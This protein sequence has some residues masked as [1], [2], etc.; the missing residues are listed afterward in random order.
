ML[1]WYIQQG[2]ERPIYM[3]QREPLVRASTAYP[4]AAM[5]A[6]FGPGRFGCQ[7]DYMAA[8][9]LAEEFDH[10]ILY[11]IGQ[12]YVADPYGAAA[13][14]WVRLHRTFLW[15][16]RLARARDVQLTWAGPNM[17]RPDI[18]GGDAPPETP[19]I[20]AYGYDMGSDLDAAMAEQRGGFAW[21]DVTPA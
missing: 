20:A 4:R 19:L 15:W 18:R 6:A 2:P 3:V 8:L 13:E 12:P 7:L 11:G 17:F 10:W 5:E 21:S 9:A 14:Q 1:N 16:L